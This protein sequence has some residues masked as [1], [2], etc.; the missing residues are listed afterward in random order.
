LEPLQEIS[1]DFS[2]R[3]C[4]GTSVKTWNFTPPQ[5]ER[6][7]QLNSRMRRTIKGAIRIRG[8]RLSLF[9]RPC[10]RRDSFVGGMCAERRGRRWASGQLA[11]LP[12]AEQ[13]VVGQARRHQGIGELAR[14]EFGDSE[15]RDW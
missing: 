3:F 4:I 5:L 10:D 9:Q 15:S 13:K 7:E 11:E 12:P 6:S 14:I 2:F 8:S 1:D